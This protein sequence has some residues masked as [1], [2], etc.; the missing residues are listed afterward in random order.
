MCLSRSLCASAGKSRVI[1]P[2]YIFPALNCLVLVSLCLMLPQISNRPG[3]NALT[4]LNKAFLST[5]WLLSGWFLFFTPFWVNYAWNS[6][7]ISRFRNTKT[8]LSDTNNHARVKVTEITFFPYSDVWCFIVAID[9]DF[10]NSL[11][12]WEIQLF[13]YFLVRVRWLDQYN[14]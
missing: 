6:E 10:K 7:E 4:S 13:I 9:T 1:R 5:K 2:D 3:Y 8:S 11:T 14:S 12:F